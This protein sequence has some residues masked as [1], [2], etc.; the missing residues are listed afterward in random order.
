VNES[1]PQ[2]L[3]V[4]QRRAIFRTLLDAQDAGA[5]VRESRAAVAGQFGVSEEQV[6][7]IEQEGVENEWPPL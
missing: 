4:D 1:T 7:Q 6:K 3:T 2:P 5:S